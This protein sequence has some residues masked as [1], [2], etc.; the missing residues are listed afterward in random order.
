MP[1]QLYALA[2][3]WARKDIR[4]SHSIGFGPLRDITEWNE[5]YIQAR[6]RHLLLI[7]HHHGEPINLREW[8]QEYTASRR[9]SNDED[10]SFAWVAMNGDALYKQYPDRWILVDKAQVIDSASDPQQLL[11]MA[12]R[13]GILEPFITKTAP[14][15]RPGKAVYG[16]QVI[17]NNR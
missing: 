17:R 11:E 7:S 6:A 12:R 15:E 13:R 9:Y 3:A 1:D 5:T 10:G 4:E 2:V 8:S 14:P 16:G